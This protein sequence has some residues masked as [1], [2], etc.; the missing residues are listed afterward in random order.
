M[1][2]TCPLCQREKPAHRAKKLYGVPVCRKC[3]YRFANRREI[4]FII[5]ALIWWPISAVLLMLMQISLASL[6]VSLDAINGLT[7]IAE[8]TVLP[9]VFYCK[10]GM[11][12]YSPGKF[13][14]G[15][16][17]V[18]RATFAPIGIT[19][20]FKRNLPLII[21]FMPLLVAF[22]LRKGHRL[23]DRWAQSKVIWKKYD[24]HPV[25]TGQLAC[26]K[27]QYNLTGNTSGRCPE[28]GT[29]VSAANQARIASGPSRDDLPDIAESPDGIVEV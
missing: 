13:I 20:S 2:I 22:D 1:N 11:N 29:P 4:A 26:E 14:C 8:W 7:L 12:G 24:Q 5:D 23:G 15:L 17:A 6:W 27:C 10:D 18:D 9:L 25:F 16:R 19:S 28:C 3:Y 21:P